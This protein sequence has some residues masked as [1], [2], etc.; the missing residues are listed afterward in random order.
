MGR[1][2]LYQQQQPE[3]QPEA[4]A[5]AKNKPL[6]RSSIRIR[7]QAC[8]HHRPAGLLAIPQ[9]I[10][11]GGRMQKASYDYTLYGPNTDQL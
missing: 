5:P 8:R 2:G 1:H 9:S 4:A 6:S 3:H 10:R 11:V 7:P